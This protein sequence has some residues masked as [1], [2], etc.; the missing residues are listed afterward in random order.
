MQT[1]ILSR[2]RAHAADISIDPASIDP[3]RDDGAVTCADGAV[4]CAAV[5]VT[6]YDVRDFSVFRGGLVLAGGGVD[7]HRGGGHDYLLSY[8]RG[9]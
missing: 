6:A 8:R 9:Q 2:V 4:T 5:V 7:V 3:A 1:N